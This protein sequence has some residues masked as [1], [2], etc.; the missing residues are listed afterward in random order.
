MRAGRPNGPAIGE[1]NWRWRRGYGEHSWLWS[2][3]ELIEVGSA[4]ADEM[5][6]AFLRAEIGS[7]RYS[8]R[9]NLCLEQLGWHRRL[10]DLSD[11]TSASENE[12]RRAILQ[13][14]RGYPDQA[15]FAGF[16]RDAVWRRVMLEPSDLAN[17][18]YANDS[19][20][21]QL[22]MRLSGGT[23]RVR[24][25]ARNF[26]NG[27]YSEET[28]HIGQVVA[29]LRSGQTFAPLIAVQSDDASLVL[30]EGHSRATAYVIERHAENV[31]ALVASAPNMVR[32]I[33][34]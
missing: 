13:G 34:Y 23:R 1:C 15:L 10:V 28:A 12:A 29:A 24:D 3:I 21:N 22:L 7:S 19:R 17:L 14:Y 31:E 8:A 2:W 25:G 4:T 9:I 33:W 20:G 18:R 16:P 11:T 26:T 5:V 6:A 32:W 30:M 27:P